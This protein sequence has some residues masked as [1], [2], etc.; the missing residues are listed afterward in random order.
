MELKRIQAEV[1][2]TFVYV[3]HDQEEALTLSNRIAVMRAGRVEQRGTPEELYE[4]PR[5]RFVADFIRTTNLLPGV[6]DRADDGTA[7]VRLTGARCQVRA[8]ALVP[9]RA[10]DL[11]VRPEAIEL[12]EGPAGGLPTAGLRADDGPAL[13]GRV[14]QSA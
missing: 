14:E 7:I 12:P 13:L 8:G 1:G 6:V 3:T 4:R 2:I 11:S 5:T 9:G 10:V